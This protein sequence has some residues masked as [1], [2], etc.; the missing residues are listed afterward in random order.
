MIRLRR[1]SWLE[2]IRTGPSPDD[3]ALLQISRELAMQLDSP[4]WYKQIAWGSFDRGGVGWMFSKPIISRE[5]WLGPLGVPSAELMLPEYLKGKLSLDEWRTLI[6]MHMVRLKFYNSGRVS[7]RLGL[8]LLALAAF[9][10]ILLLSD[11][12]VGRSWSPILVFSAWSILILL[13]FLSVRRSM[14]KWE[15]ELDRKMADRFGTERVSQ[16]LEEMQNLDPRATPSNSLARFLAFWSPSIRERLEELGNPPL[17]GPPKPSRIPKIGLR[18][19][20]IIIVVGFAIFWGSGVVAGNL[21]ARGQET[22]ACVTNT[23]AALVI[24]AAV[25]YWSAILGALSMVPVVVRRV[26]QA[27]RNKKYR[28]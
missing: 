4:F 25:G 19:R 12:L 15:F 18:G 21:Y 2:R 28:A 5:L 17:I 23:C 11:I 13:F 1:L 16:I 24:I 3:G 7:A 27:R 9:V 6:A 14:R 8:T 20:A 10:P 22:V 26:R